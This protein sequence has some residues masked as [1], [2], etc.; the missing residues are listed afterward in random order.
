MAQKQLGEFASLYKKWNGRGVEDAGCVTSREFDGFCTSFKNALKKA[1]TTIGADLVTFRKGHYDFSCFIERSGKYA[2]V[3]FDV[4][5]GGQA[6]D[7]TRSNPL[8]GFLVRTA[9]HAK[10]YHGGH[11]NFA[12][13]AE[14]TESIDRRLSEEH[15]SF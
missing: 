7:F 12:N 4:P 14:L 10:D 11:N 5:R 3:S 8:Q 1:V 6:I 15:R 9:A 2:Y 13:L